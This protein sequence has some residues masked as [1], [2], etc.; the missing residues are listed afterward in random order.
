MNRKRMAD[1]DDD[2]L[3]QALALSLRRP[4]PPELQQPPPPDALMHVPVIV[5]GAV[6]DM[7][8]LQ[9]R[10]FLDAFRR[11]GSLRV[12]PRELDPKGKNSIKDLDQVMF[13]R[14]SFTDTEWS[15]FGFWAASPPRDVDDRLDSLDK[16]VTWFDAS[17]GQ[18]DGPG[19]THQDALPF[20]CM[21]VQLELGLILMRIRS[22]QIYC[23][24]PFSAFKF[25]I[26]CGRV[27]VV[28]KLLEHTPNLI[29]LELAGHVR[30]LG[31]YDTEPL[32]IACSSQGIRPQ[33]RLE[34]VNTLLSAYRG[35]AHQQGRSGNIFFALH[36]R[37]FQASFEYRAL[38]AAFMAGHAECAEALT[39]AG[40]PLDAS[41]HTPQERAMVQAILD[42]NYAS[43][44][45]M[46]TRVHVQA[47]GMTPENIESAR[48]LFGG[49]APM[50]FG[51]L[52]G[53]L[54]LEERAPPGGWGSLDP[55]GAKAKALRDA[56]MTQTQLR[57]YESRLLHSEMQRL[58]DELLREQESPRLGH[59]LLAFVCNPD[60]DP[61][62][63]SRLPQAL[64]DALAAS[65][66]MPATIIGGA[67]LPFG[68]SAAQ[69]SA[70][71]K[72]DRTCTFERLSHELRDRAQRSQLP[73]AFL[74]SGH[75]NHG[76]PKTL[77]FTRADGTLAPIVDRE[78]IATLFGSHARRSGCESGIQLLVLNGCESAELARLCRDR[79][80]PFVVGWETACQDEAA[81]LFV[82]GFFRALGRSARRSED[83]CSAFDA[84]KAAVTE[85]KRLVRS[86]DDC[87][88]ED[89]PY[90]ELR[91]PRLHVPNSLSFAAGVPVLLTAEPSMPERR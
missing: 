67:T 4:P 13:L 88:E 90:F 5:V 51:Y 6:P 87:A 17:D 53:K 57:N 2:E 52:V 8:V 3:Q 71:V 59:E 70:A 69:W 81:Y 89:V 66:G 27:E 33:A 78:A 42:R 35:R 65:Y 49:N 31:T 7:A 37:G 55:E 26:E 72:E 63:G 79:G 54:N 91:D 48:R 16:L 39:R 64:N 50:A 29:D 19:V 23:M 20:V 12:L 40:V 34:L 24:S 47:P 84:G 74:F 77:G 18:R 56:L 58:R 22:H 38:E 32:Y 85:K 75:A 36:R 25:A 1:D 46:M 62:P 60:K 41:A 30:E 9:L 21:R 76:S 83:Y 15:E 14:R 43:V 86:T 10:E 11:D 68:H 44:Q 82:R 45:A 80:V 28:R 73:S 61:T